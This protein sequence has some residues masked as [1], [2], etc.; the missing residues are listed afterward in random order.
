MF[1]ILSSLLRY[2]FITVIY[3]FIYG[4]IKLIY[5]DIH[6]V[7]GRQRDP[8][9]KLPYLKL[10]NRRDSLDF[11]LEEVYLLDGS[12]T[13]GRA[14]KSDITV[15]DPF[16]SSEHARFHMKDGVFFIEDLGSKNGTFVNGERLSSQA[17]PL[18]NGDRIYI[19]QLDLIYVNNAL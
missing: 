2:I 18:K 19:G 14:G 10:V 16:I 15:Q 12:K 11:K 6:S 1:E 17:V 7:N 4:I 9:G 13:V 5:L 8:G 3:L